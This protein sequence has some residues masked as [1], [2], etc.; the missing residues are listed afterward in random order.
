MTRV[1]ERKLQ[2][3]TLKG[4]KKIMLVINGRPTCVEGRKKV[5]ITKTWV[6]SIARKQPLSDTT[7]QQCGISNHESYYEYMM[8]HVS[9]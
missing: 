7:E 5:K 3:M 2:V 6:L 4:E 8:T 9:Y 1:T